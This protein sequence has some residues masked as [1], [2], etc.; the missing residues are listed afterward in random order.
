M[1]GAIAMTAVVVV[2]GIEM[3]FASRG[4]GHSHSAD[5]EALV[6]PSKDHSHWRQ[7]QGANS[8]NRFRR[9]S[10]ERPPDLQIAEEA[11]GDDE[12]EG[13][14]ANRSPST[15]QPSPMPPGLHSKR[16]ND[17]D[18][19]DSESDL[20]LDELDHMPDASNS[21]A[22]KSSYQPLPGAR[23]R[24]SSLPKLHAN[25]QLNGNMNSHQQQQKLILQCLLLEAGILFHSV[26]IGMA[27]SV[28]TGPAFVVFLLAI[29]FHQTF[30]GLA[31]GAR[32]SAL[33]FLPSSPKPWLMALAFGTTTPFGQAIGLG[34]RHLY[35]PQ[36]QVGLIVVGVTNA[37]SS[38]LLLFAGLVGLLAEDFLSDESY[39]TLTGKRRLKACGAVVAGATLMALVGA[40]A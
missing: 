1:P 13:L 37:I 24:S 5:F 21:H 14:V 27:L 40:W 39:V 23:Q 2:V 18:A 29:S 11:E 31:L 35:D 4:A 6:D 20:E 7:G 25:G 22:R 33:A 3:F 9:T 30:E 32:I 8:M 19:A 15:A 34:V 12:R 10:L 26:F 16:D 28:S 38:G 17:D 36:G